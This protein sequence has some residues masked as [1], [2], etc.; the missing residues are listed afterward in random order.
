MKPSTV[1]IIATERVNERFS[2]EL[3]QHFVDR[4]LHKMSDCPEHVGV[5]V[6]EYRT[7]YG[8]VTVV[9]S[10]DVQTAKVA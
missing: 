5:W 1:T 9:Y 10:K 6:S 8:E 3:I 4:S 2:K 7:V